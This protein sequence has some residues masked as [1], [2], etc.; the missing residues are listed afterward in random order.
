M[1]IR[2]TEAEIARQYDFMDEAAA[3]NAAVCGGRRRAFI[4]TFGCQ[5]NEADSETLAGMVSRMGYDL[6]NEVDG[7]DLVLINTCAV[8]EHAESRALSLTG[9]VKAEKK[10][11]PDM[12]IGLCG[13]MATQSHISED[14][15]KKFKYVDILFGTTEL[16]RFPEILLTRLKTGERIIEPGDESRGVVAEGLPQIRA[17]RYKVWISVMYGCNNFCSYCVVPYVRGRER[18][19]TREDVLRELEEAVKAGARDVTLLGQNVNSYGRGLYDDY[20]FADLLRDAA[21]IEGDF[22]LRFMTSHPKDLTPAL[23][24]ELGTNPKIA[25][26]LHLPLQSGCDRILALMNRGYT[27]DAYLSLVKAVREAVPDIALTTDI[28]VGFPGETEEDFNET[29]DIMRLVRFDNIYSFIYSKRR[30]TKAADMPQLPYSVK[31]ER[32]TRLTDLQAEIELEFNRGFE[33]KILE[34]LVEG[35][36]KTDD[37]RLTGRTDRGKAVHFEGPGSIIG[38]TAHVRI[39]RSETYALYGELIPADKSN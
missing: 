26:A 31:S 12:I 27:R 39:V 22:K 8:R 30:G 6:C 34:V 23:I 20:G 1:A 9:R 28:I 10:K 7:A 33:G 24:T 29:L 36:S 4:R 38:S 35:V 25:R 14:I 37:T 17:D 13:C 18:S 15:K 5:Q 21:K 16:W 19:R 11:N 3:I 2:I 32:Y